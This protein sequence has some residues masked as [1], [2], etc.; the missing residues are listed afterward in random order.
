[1]LCFNSV[2]LNVECGGHLGE[3]REGHRFN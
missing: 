1:M 3:N 2:L